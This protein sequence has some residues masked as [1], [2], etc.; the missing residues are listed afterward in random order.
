MFNVKV[1]VASDPGACTHSETS[2]MAKEMDD[3]SLMSSN[4][5]NNK[6]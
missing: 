5:S 2:S 6:T 1:A 4:S 3:E